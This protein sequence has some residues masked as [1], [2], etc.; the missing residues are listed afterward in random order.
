VKKTE[1]EIAA[2]KKRYVDRLAVVV[3]EKKVHIALAV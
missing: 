3:R 2:I 1:E